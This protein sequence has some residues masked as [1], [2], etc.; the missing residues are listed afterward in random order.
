MTERAS[1][2]TGPTRLFLAQLD[3]DVAQHPALN[4]TFLRRFG[5]EKLDRTHLAD[6]AV[7][8]YMHSRFF[9]RSLAAV[10]ANIPD[11]HA[12]SLLIQNMYE[13]V[14]EPLKLRDRAHLILLEVGLVSPDQISEALAVVGIGGDVTAYLVERGV[15][16]REVLA[17]L[18]QT[19]TEQTK[20]LTHP[21][22]FRRFLRALGVSPESI[23][24]VEPL[25]ETAQFV[26]EFE[27]ICRHGHWL[28]ALGALGPGTE[29]VVPTLYSYILKGIE[30]SEVV[31]S[32]SYVFW[33][34]HVHC[35]GGRGENLLRAIEPYLDR[36]TNRQLV[37][38]GAN[39]VL[40]ARKRW[41]DGL[42]R[43]VFR[44]RRKQ[45]PQLYDQPT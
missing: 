39:R 18:L 5:E 41:F 31:G 4:H 33:T 13:D 3:A 40:D 43:M 38:R 30:R 9:V 17:S 8:H 15:V 24:A 19:R 34:L 44:S 12:R 37:S 14:G 28:E 7:Q 1:R 26:R 29:S 45:A 2:P 36:P 11:E 21:A 20:E 32:E 16:K 6:F 10:A 25:P 23:S 22:L 42:E 35:D 27:V